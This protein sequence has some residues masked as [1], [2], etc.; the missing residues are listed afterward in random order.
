MLNASLRE[1]PHSRAATLVRVGETVAARKS[2]AVFHNS[3][4][5]LGNIC[6]GMRL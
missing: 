4:G 2:G 6:D 5:P 1:E 3:G